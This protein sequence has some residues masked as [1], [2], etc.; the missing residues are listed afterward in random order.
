MD[1]IEAKQ[2]ITNLP[3]VLD[4]DK[5]PQRKR[6]G[7]LW[8]VSFVVLTL[9][10]GGYFGYTAWDSRHDETLGNPCSKFGDTWILTLC[11][12]GT[13]FLND[14]TVTPD[15]QIIAVGATTGDGGDFASRGSEGEFK[16]LK[17]LVSGSEATWELVPYGKYLRLDSIPD[18]TIGT[19]GQ[20]AHDGQ[21]IAILEWA[22]L[23]DR[24]LPQAQILEDGLSWNA[25]AAGPD[26]SFVVVGTKANTTTVTPE[27]ADNSTTSTV[28]PDDTAKSILVVRKHPAYGDEYSWERKFTDQFPHWISTSDVAVDADSN[29]YITGSAYSNWGATSALIK[30]DPQGEMVWGTPFFIFDMEFAESIESALEDVR[31][32]ESATIEISGMFTDESGEVSSVF[33]DTSD[34][35]T[36]VE[37]LPD[38][39]IV[40][41]G[42]RSLTTGERQGMLTRFSSSGEEK[43]MRST[44]GDGHDYFNDLVVTSY[45]DIIA[46]GAT[47]VPD[48]PG[49]GLPAGDAW[50]VGYSSVGNELWSRIYG[51]SGSDVFLGASITPQGQILAV[52]YTTSTDGNLKSTYGQDAALM[53]RLDQRGELIPM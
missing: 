28:D 11:N 29:I 22:H 53:V 18:G 13:S 10:V 6:E 49:E 5:E 50:V 33:Y 47:G 9:V 16:G 24:N 26:S 21:P 17:V 37:I 30:L 39:D 44:G 43:W 27:D 1:R 42:Y 45:G 19:I 12:S 46:I 23:T 7:I 4:Q 8:I 51:G 41:V 34:T 25:I 35:Y 48:S 38:G 2:A 32:S 20:E 3:E 36:A 15:G 52:G 40:A 14:V 31:D